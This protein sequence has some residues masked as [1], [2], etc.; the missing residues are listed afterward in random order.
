MTM[1]LVLCWPLMLKDLQSSLVVKLLLVTDNFCLVTL[2]QLLLTDEWSFIFFLII[3]PFTNSSSPMINY[4]LVLF[5]SCII[6]FTR[7]PICISPSAAICP[8][9][10]LVRIQISSNPWSFFGQTRHKNIGCLISNWG[11]ISVM[12]LTGSFCIIP[13]LNRFHYFVT[14]VSSTKILPAIWTI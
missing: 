5:S 14:W 9:P 10:F 12:V 7:I 6:W 1:S 8:F 4:Q 3:I 2:F 11:Q 13:R